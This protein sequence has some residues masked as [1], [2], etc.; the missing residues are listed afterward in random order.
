MFS[1]AHTNRKDYGFLLMQRNRPLSRIQPPPP[2]GSV[3]RCRRRRKNSA[4]RRASRNFW[5]PPSPYF[6]R[7][8]RGVSEK[9]R[10]S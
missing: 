4:R 3:P 7:V 5:T 6:S 8:R 10:S 9:F 1:L 2:A